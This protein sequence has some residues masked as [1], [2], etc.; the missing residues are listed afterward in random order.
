M[1]YRTGPKIVTDGLVLCLDAAVRNSYP[2][3]GSTWGDLSGNG[4]NGTLAPTN[5]TFSFLN[6]GYLDFNGSNQYASVSDSN[7]QLISNN[8]TEMT[9]EAFAKSDIASNA[10]IAGNFSTVTGSVGAR[11]NWRALG[12]VVWMSFGEAG[13]D[14]VVT[15]SVS[16]GVWYHIVGTVIENSSV[17]IYINGVIK[18]STS[19]TKTFNGTEPFYI[20]KGDF[21]EYFNGAISTIRVYNRALYSQEIRQ[22]FEAT[23]GRFGL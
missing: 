15:A 18:N 5:P 9:I 2:G 14:S 17:S 7:N 10:S 19:T 22:N 13:L 8:L 16:P 12:G 20:G 23:K 3:T 11:L 4:N 6:G 1:S 21:G